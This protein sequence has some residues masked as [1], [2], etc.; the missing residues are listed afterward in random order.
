MDPV[1]FAF[2]DPNSDL[3]FHLAA[4]HSRLELALLYLQG[5]TWQA[6]GS[7]SGLFSLRAE[8]Q[9]WDAAKMAWDGQGAITAPQG[10]REGTF[11]FRGAGEA[12]GLQVEQRL[13]LVSG[14]ALVVFQTQVRNAGSRLLDLT[15]LHSFALTIPADAYELLS[16]RSDWG[17]EFQL[18]R[19]PLTAPVLLETRFGRSSKGWHP[20]VALRKPS[21]GILATSVAWS[22]NWSIRL[23]PAPR[24]GWRISAGLNE[25]EFR[26]TLAPGEALDGPPVLLALGVDLDDVSQQF[27]RAARG[28]LLENALSQGLPVEW[29]PW[30]SFE[31]VAI[32]EATFLKNVE[33]AQKLGVELC[34]LD[35]GWFGPDDPRSA[36]FDYRGD[37]EQVNRERFPHGLAYLGREVHARG[38]RFGLWIEIEG[39]GRRAH[40]ARA[41][42]DFAAQRQGQPLGYV[43][44]GNPAAREWAYRTLRRLVRESG[45]DW[46]KL[47]FN[48]DPGAG[49][50][51][52]DHGHAAG[53][54]LLM[55]YQGYYALLDRL[56]ARFP[57]LVLEACASGGLRLDWGM[58]AHTHLAFTS[59]PDW[60]VHALQVFWGASQML[61][62]RA[63]LR[64]SAS[65]WRSPGRPP[66]Q[67]FHLRD[68]SLTRA[69]LDY[70]VHVA[71]LSACGFSQKLPDLP[72][73]VAERLAGLIRLYKEQVRRFVREADLYHL[74]GQ[75][76]RD[77]TG[78]RWVAFQY[79]L[80]DD[81][82]HLLFV[83][84]LPGAEPRRI[85]RL[86][87]L[88][89]ERRYRLRPLEGGHA[90]E[91]TGRELLETGLP[92]DG[93]G[94]EESLLLIVE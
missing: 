27:A 69:R 49:C 37:W 8:D 24:G 86:R 83:F 54:G 84:R 20:W 85:L 52:L 66:E 63:L 17:A 65:E 7:P 43:C 32:D 10:G 72:V 21:G 14:A 45:C 61:P 94:E 79:A 60:P 77:G 9:D 15:R 75:P 89:P 13:R 50:D 87:A 82:A 68:P 35:A 55:H 18:E 12:A 23:D 53:D 44:L 48:L 67:S 81:A 51:R 19:Q 80:P 88:Q 70:A 42:P 64:W 76:Q 41:H 39:L 40:L 6:T 33:V 26:K 74:T 73:W 5:E 90:W 31:D 29:N 58:L 92:V 57:D 25:W 22:G 1:C 2:D 46:L 34:T 62:P 11:R 56:R 91:H 16:F 4:H 47:D 28:W 78:E 59:D 36:W 30:W 38:L 3:Q 93:L 71:M